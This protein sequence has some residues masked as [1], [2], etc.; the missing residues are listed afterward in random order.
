M[1][2]TKE[3]KIMENEKLGEHLLRY[4]YQAFNEEGY[5]KFED[6]AKSSNHDRDKALSNLNIIVPNG[7]PTEAVKK[8][9]DYKEKRARYRINPTI[10][11]DY[12]NTLL[13]T[14]KKKEKIYWLETFDR[15]IY[16]ISVQ[17]PDPKQLME[18]IKI[19]YGSTSL[20]N[21]LNAVYFFSYS[22]EIPKK[23]NNRFS[24][25]FGKRLNYVAATTIP[26]Y[27]QQRAGIKN[28]IDLYG[29]EEKKM[30][31]KYKAKKKALELKVGKNE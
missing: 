18:K 28:I 21:V 24:I 6:L 14:Q 5:N 23:R 11:D 19:V 20:K 25:S 1:T 3:S 15:I 2:Q 30:I 13:A 22:P 26:T 9:L 4:L 29:E 17:E 31:R 12:Q 8:A 27:K 16:L 7:K 10:F